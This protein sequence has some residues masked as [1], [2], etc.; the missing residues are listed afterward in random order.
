[1]ATTA[2]ILRRSIAWPPD[3]GSWAFLLSPMI[4]GLTVGGHW[5]ETALYVTVAAIC[6]FL[7]RQP[8]TVAIKALS[9]RRPRSDLPAAL[10]WTAI[11]VSIGLFH[12]LGLVLR[13]MGYLLYLAIPGIAVFAWYLV[14]VW[15]RDERRQL[16]LE[17]LAAGVFALS[18]PA[19]YWAAVGEPVPAGWWLWLLTWAHSAASIVFVYMRLRQRVLDASPSLAKRLSMAWPA[20]SLT[21]LNLLAVAALGVDRIVPPEL[22]IAYVPQWLEALRGSWKPA[23]GCRPTAIGLR[24][25]LVTALYTL[26]FSLCW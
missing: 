20:L 22:A 1:M 21:T 17:V 26:I 6:G 25:L 13:G 12:V 16:G 4:I 11:Y 18:A 23:I 8:V 2:R 19:G 24:Q 14:L 7:V 10:I 5:S 15:N 3:H 9:G